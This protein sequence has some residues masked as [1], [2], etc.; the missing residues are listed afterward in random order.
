MLLIV[1]N[2]ALQQYAIYD[3]HKK[4]IVANYGIDPQVSISMF[5]L[6]GPVREISAKDRTDFDDVLIYNEDTF[7]ISNKN[8]G[9]FDD[10]VQ[11]SSVF[12]KVVDTIKFNTPT[13]DKLRKLIG[14]DDVESIG[15]AEPIKDNSPAAVIYN[16]IIDT[17]VYVEGCR[18]V[19]S[20]VTGGKGKVKM[21]Y[22]SGRDVT[23]DI[24]EDDDRDHDDDDD[25]D[26]DYSTS[27]ETT[28]QVF[29]EF[30]EIPGQYFSY[31]HVKDI[32]DALE[33]QYGE[34]RVA[35]TSNF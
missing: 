1:Y 9:I 33:K 12:D 17:D 25:D 26:N 28:P 30:H 24:E 29:M 6:T 13:K 34:T 27:S 11:E 31:T 7:E 18:G 3:N 32:Q 20:S 8:Y 23:V 16:P 35:K 15:D 22:L 4:V 14:A 10:D 21:V 5:G 19:M 2:N